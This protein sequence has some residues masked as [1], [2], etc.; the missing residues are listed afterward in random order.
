MEPI[1]SNKETH[2]PVFYRHRD[3]GRLDRIWNSTD[4]A[5]SMDVVRALVEAAPTA[6]PIVLG[7]GEPTLR[8]DLPELIT[9]LRAQTVL[10]TDGLVF[11]EPKIVQHL[12]ECGL[13]A[14]RLPLHTAR[15]DAYDWLTGIPGS[16]RRIRLALKCCTTL[17]IDVSAEVTLTRPTTPYLEET[18]AW[19]VRFGVKSVRFR[20]L[21]RRGP[22]T[23]E[24]I[25]LAPR[26]GLLEPSLEAAIQL[27]LRHGLQI[28]VEGL[29]HCAI[30]RF[31]EV[32]VPT[33]RWM[34]PE[35][36]ELPSLDM[37]VDDHAS[38]RGCTPCVP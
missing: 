23:M 11:H 5:P 20:M 37:A 14:V 34:A 28:E 33:P 19:L 1:E 25:T 35:G 12:V 6:S 38:P 31:P 27:G 16:H 36:I 7:G 24:Y 10:A 29:P 13:S 15:S 22:A 18:V 8:T 21:R 9:S 3:A 2:I 30:P 32:H 26:L 4:E 17:G